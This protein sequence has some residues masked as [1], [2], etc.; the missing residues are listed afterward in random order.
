MPAMTAT[1]YLTLKQKLARVGEDAA[2]WAA[3]ARRKQ[4]ENA[5]LQDVVKA[6]RRR[7]DRLEAEKGI[8]S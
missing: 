8:K 5:E 7:I 2:Q 6:L 1:E 4:T 3:E